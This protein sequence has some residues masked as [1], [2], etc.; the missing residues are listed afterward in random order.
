MYGYKRDSINFLIGSFPAYWL[1][2][3]IKIDLTDVIKV[4]HFNI[5]H[6]FKQCGRKK[7]HIV[8]KA[9]KFTKCFESF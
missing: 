3:V 4:D 5:E 7:E 9:E 1:T 6:L 2:D 8:C